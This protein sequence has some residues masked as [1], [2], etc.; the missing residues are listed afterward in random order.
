MP[1]T[2]CNSI[3]DMRNELSKIDLS[4]VQIAISGIGH[5]GLGVLEMLSIFEM[6][7]LGPMELLSNVHKPGICLLH[8]SDYLKTKDGWF[9]HTSYMKHPENYKSVLQKYLSN[10]DIYIATHFWDKQT[11]PLLSHK[12]YTKNFNPTIIGDISCDIKDAIASTIRPSTFNNPFYGYDKELGIETD[13]WKNDCVTVMAVDNLPNG[14]PRESS[15]DFSNKMLSIIPLLSEGVDDPMIE[16]ATI[17]DRGKLTKKF[18][19]L[20]EWINT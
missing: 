10:T 19:Y 7:T 20:N 4:G 5:V 18:K 3:S 15:K 6:N 2:A 1:V 12:D 16:G 13:P 17:C 14:L 8:T 9:G 11:G